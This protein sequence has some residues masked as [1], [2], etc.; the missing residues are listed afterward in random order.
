LVAG[1]VAWAKDRHMVLE[2]VDGDV[3][4]NEYRSFIEHLDQ[5]SSLPGPT[6]GEGLPPTP[7][8][9]IGNIMVYERLG[10][11]TLHGMQTFYSFTHDKRVLDIAIEWSDAFLH[12]RNDPVTGRLQWT[13][14]RELCWPNKETNDVLALYSGAENGDVIEHIVN[15]AKLILEDASLWNQTAP[16]DKFGFGATY[17]DRAKTYVRECQRSA[18]TTIVP[19][20]LQNTRVG[21]RLYRPESPAYVK[22]FNETG[23][24][25]WNQQ[26][27]IVGGLL[28]LAQCHRLLNDGNTNIV[29]YEQ[30]TRDAAAWFFENAK[31]VSVNGKNCYDWGYLAVADPE[32]HREDTGHSFYDVFVLRAY[33]ANLGVERVQLQRLINTALFVINRGSNVFAGYVNGVTNQYREARKFLHYPWIEMSVLDKRLYEL[34]A[35]AV[36]VSHE[37]YDDIPVEAAVLY[38]K[39]YWATHEPG[40]E[41]VDNAKLAP[42]R[43]PPPSRH[44]NE[45]PL[46]A[47]LNR[48]RWLT[49]GITLLCWL[50]VTLLLKFFRRFKT[51]VVSENQNS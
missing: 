51:S 47:L 29:F 32:E 11:A 4:T 26:Q 27:C 46:L 1:H 16:S 19:W 12:A 31:L 15:T 36:L 50:V 30:I 44:D 37:F 8:N 7:S 13:G 22:F 25:P 18:E 42:A 17:L 6:R 41:V 23:P 3:T 24:L 38:A 43:L 20:Y 40:P 2:R 48:H 39:H 34:T 5:Q 9:N 28:R 21:Y 10:G 33:D 45:W 49:A 35:N 14:K